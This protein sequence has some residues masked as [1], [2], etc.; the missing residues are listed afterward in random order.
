MKRVG[1]ASLILTALVATV[2]IVVLYANAKAQAA[3]ASVGWEYL[4]VS[5]PETG[6]RRPFSEGTP[7]N[8]EPG[9]PEYPLTERSLDRLGADG[10]ELVATTPDPESTGTVYVYIFKRRK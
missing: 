10:W 9:F 4:V 5:N 7:A 2:I 3:S 1:L 8:K 6:Y